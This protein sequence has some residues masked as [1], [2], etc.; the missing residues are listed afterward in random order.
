[1][2]CSFLSVPFDAR[3]IGPTHHLAVWLL[4]IDTSQKLLHTISINY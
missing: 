3:A 4:L 1:M 2:L